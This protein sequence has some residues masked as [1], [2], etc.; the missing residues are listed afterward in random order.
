M[1]KIAGFDINDEWI[2]SCR[3][4]KN[5]PHPFRPYEWLVEKERTPSGA[6]ED[7]LTVFLTNR[8]CPF[9]CLMCD[10]WKNTVDE[11]LPEGALAGQLG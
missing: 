6:V 9:R 11:P 5:N 3:G 4:R 8:E 7:V 1:N 10:L 2:L